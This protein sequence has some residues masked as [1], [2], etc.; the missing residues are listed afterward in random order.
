MRYKERFLFTFLILCLI[1]S[2]SANAQ[3]KP[4]F[5]LGGALRFNYNYSDWKKDS[6]KKGGDFGYDVFR[7]NLSGTYKKI[8]FDA[9][10]R[11][12]ADSSGGHMLKHGWFGYDFNENHQIQVG[13]TQVPFGA[14]P[15]T[16]NNFFFNI[17]YYLG[18]E[19]DSD[20][21]IKYSFQKNRWQ[22]ALAFFKNSD[23]LDFGNKQNLS[24]NRYSYDVAG[25]DKEI[26]HGNIQVNFNWGS[27]VVQQLGLSVM[28]GGLY[29][30]DTEKVGLHKALAVHYT[31]LYKN[32]DLKAQYTTYSMN[33]KKGNDEK[34]NPLNRDFV[35]MGAYGA[36]YDVAS[37]ADTYQLSLA[38]NIPI[39][40]GILDNIRI[41]NDFSMMHKRISGYKDSYQN[42]SGILLTTGPIFTYIDYALGKNHAWLGDAWNDSFAAGDPSNKWNARFNINMGYYF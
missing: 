12:Y 40:R 28:L 26:N 3:D 18:L 25:R 36:T 6:K 19:D 32:W 4:H 34:G 22:L 2:V 9:E 21:G 17:N 30:M 23:I 7:L 1:F 10:Y 42:V 20:M 16:S 14:L 35:T 5:E 13:L 37:K 41:Y 29:N 15:V 11:F 27:K 38:Y 33:P 31:F 24:P 39:N 8:L